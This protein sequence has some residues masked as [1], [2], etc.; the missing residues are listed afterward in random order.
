MSNSMNVMLNAH[1]V[2]GRRCKGCWEK[3]PSRVV[4]LLRDLMDRMK[5]SSI[6]IIVNELLKMLL[7]V[8]VISAAV[9][10][11]FIYNLSVDQ[12]GF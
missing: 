4:E 10:I 5:M 6:T 11:H 2:G 12:T 1:W 7:P 9:K 8:I 3:K